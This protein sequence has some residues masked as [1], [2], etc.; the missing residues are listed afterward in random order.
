MAAERGA[1]VP[2]G[3]PTSVREWWISG[4]DIFLLRNFCPLPLCESITETPLFLCRLPFTRC[5]LRE[6]LQFNFCD[7]I[8]EMNRIHVIWGFHSSEDQAEVFLGCDTVVFQGDTNISEDPAAYN[9]RVNKVLQ[10][11]GRWWW[12]QQGLPKL[13][14]PTATLSQSKRAWPEKE[15]VFL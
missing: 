7:P 10:N 15:F 8:A 11:T 6:N 4:S 13:W 1:E 3:D 14:C 9:F 5:K 2:V 12:R